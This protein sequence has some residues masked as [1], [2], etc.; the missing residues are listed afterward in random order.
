M[1]IGSSDLED[2]PVQ[3]RTLQVR[4][5]E[6]HAGKGTCQL[7]PSEFMESQNYNSGLLSPVVFPPWHGWRLQ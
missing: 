5:T 6:V 4:K 2:H 7:S 3:P 1:G